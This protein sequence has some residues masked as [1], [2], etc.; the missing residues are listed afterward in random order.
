[1]KK[2]KCAVCDNSFQLNPPLYHASGQKLFFFVINHPVLICRS[3]IF[4][5]HDIIAFTLDIDNK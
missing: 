4:M 3:G 2:I 1:M 5:T